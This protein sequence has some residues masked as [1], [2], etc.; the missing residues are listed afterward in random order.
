MERFIKGGEILLGGYCIKI[1]KEKYA[2]LI[3]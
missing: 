1:G 3:N 2:Q